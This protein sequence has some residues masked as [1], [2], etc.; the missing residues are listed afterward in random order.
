MKSNFYLS[1]G[2]CLLGPKYVT[3]L[4][5]RLYPGTNDASKR[6]PR[7]CT[8]PTFSRSL[9][10]I[11]RILTVPSPL[12]IPTPS[13]LFNPHCKHS[14][15]S[16]CSEFHPLRTRHHKIKD[17]HRVKQVIPR[18]MDL[19]KVWPACGNSLARQLWRQVHPCSV[20]HKTKMPHSK[21]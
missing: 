7:I 18:K 3:C 11:L 13:A 2:S 12:H 4:S 21:L 8:K 14:G 20:R 17:L 16:S 5:S 6:G 9:S 15:L 1:S 10:Q 19:S